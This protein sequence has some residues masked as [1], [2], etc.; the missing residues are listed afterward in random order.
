MSCQPRLTGR[1][2]S[3]AARLGEQIVAIEA[4]DLSALDSLCQ[5]ARQ[6]LIETGLP[7]EVTAA[8]TLAYRDIMNGGAVAVRSSAMAEDQPSASLSP[9]MPTWGS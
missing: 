9:I 6:H 2:N 5:Q 8:V 4:T 3:F 7:S 1:R